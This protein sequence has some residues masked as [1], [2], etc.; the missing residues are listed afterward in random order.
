MTQAYFEQIRHDFPMIASSSCVYL[1][2][3]ATMHKS[4]TVIEAVSTFYAKEYATVNRSVY[5][6]AR[7]ATDLYNAA[8]EQVAQFLHA[9]SPAEVIFTRGTTDGINMI[10]DSMAHSI[11]KPGSR[12][13]VSHMEHHS[14]LIPWQMAART[15]GATL[16]AIPVADDGSLRLD[17]LQELLSKG[18]VAVVALT[19]ASN[20]LGVINPIA[21]VAQMVH[22]HGA[23]LVVDGAQAAAHLPIDVQSLGCDAYACSSHKIGGPTGVGALWARY[24][25]LESLPPTRGGGDM[26]DVVSMDGAMWADLP[27]KF[28]PGTPAIAEAIGFGVATQYLSALPSPSSYEES[29]EIRLSGG[30][31]AIPGLCFVGTASPRIP[32]RS[33][34]IP[35][36]HSL[37]LASGLDIAHVAVRSGHM[38]CQPL[39]QRFS[40]PFLTRASLSFYNTMEDID[41]FLEALQKTLKR[42][43]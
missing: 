4:R 36:V 22:A 6:S 28:E 5:L 8:R 12:I 26:V 10:A 31:K 20:V 35:G 25:L 9:S 32:L 41:V 40:V 30:L 1:D 33:F 21:T 42:L 17:A 43:L 29:L 39:L 27:H 13:L 18:A 24:S 15:P 7:R 3:A 34:Y 16:E 37:D 14:N 2:S 11:L 38:C 19:H 23:L